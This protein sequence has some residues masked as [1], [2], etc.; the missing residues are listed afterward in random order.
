MTLDPLPLTSAIVP[1]A[2]VTCPS[3]HTARQAATDANEAI[4]NYW[5][6]QRC[7]EKWTESRLATVA[8]YEVWVR[9]RTNAT[10]P[11]VLA[12]KLSA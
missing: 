3:C 4:G 5:S 7:G 6:C 1:A 11:Q 10:R 12:G 2:P 9:E 8:E